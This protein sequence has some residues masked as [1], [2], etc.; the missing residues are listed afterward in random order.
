M[1]GILET[2]RKQ[3][4]RMRGEEDIMKK[5]RTIAGIVALG[6]GVGV[7]LG[8]CTSGQ[9]GE[10]PNGMKNTGVKAEAR[11]EYPEEPVYKNSDDRW[12]SNR[13]KR[14]KLTESFVEAYDAFAIETTAELFQDNNEN[15]VYSP[16]SLYYALALAASGAEGETREQMLD[17]LGYDDIGSLTDDCKGSFEALY[18]VPN[19]E[20][21]KPNEWGEYDSEGRYTLAISNSLWA[22]DSLEMK[23][24]FAKNGADNFYA[25]IFSGDLQSQE[26]A[27]AKALWV[28]ERTHGLLEPK[29]EPAGADALLS[30]INTV[31][32]YD[33]WI[34]RFDKERTEEDAFFCADGTE[35]SC[36]FMNM[37]M[38][39][40]G[41]RK[42]ENYTE[43]SLSLKN[44]TMTFYLPDEGVDVQELIENAKVLDSI[45]NGNLEY[46]SGEV[47][48][49]VPKFSYGSSLSMNDMLQALGMEQ[50][51]AES[52]DFTGIADTGSLFI[53]TVK[54]DARLGID[55]DGVEGAAFTE[56]LYCG[57]AMPTGKAEMILDR[58]FLYTVKNN[59]V[60]I[61]VGICKNPA[62]E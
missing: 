6:I 12:K 23:V 46:A 41:F 27:E 14:Q 18:Y 62:E 11:A 51:F 44:G 56:I 9:N 38:G 55:E 34:N 43:S 37:K 30:I 3:R 48:W 20:N 58:P 61:F 8:G 36:D 28:N 40:H 26:V 24:S 15:I 29:A 19:E 47:T 60:L 33:E 13:E 54:Q 22:D 49:K 7:V 16:L 4:Y 10:E 50:A 31:Y 53:S 45:L 21:N 2:E 42:G 35:V 17:V 32:F 1:H 25:D 5:N 39:S 57:A 52:A 59:G